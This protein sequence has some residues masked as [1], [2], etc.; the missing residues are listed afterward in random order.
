VVYTFASGGWSATAIANVNSQEA[1]HA[2]GMDHSLNCNSVMSYCGSG[3]G[4]FS[5]TCDG[6]C[7]Q[8]CQGAAG[9]RLFHEDFC[10]VGNDR[11][12]EIEELT[13]IFGGNEPDL[14]PPSVEIVSP[15]DGLVLPEGAD[16]NLR[17]IVDDDY[18]GY[19]W[20]FVI[21]HQGEV[22]YDQVDYDREVDAQYRAA[23]NLVNLEP[24]TYEIVVEAADHF[25]H[26]SSDV[27]TFVV[28][29]EV[30]PGDTEAD[31]TAGGGSGGEGGTA[32]E[33]SGGEGTGTATHE[34]PTAGAM[35]DGDDGC[36]CTSGPGR[37]RTGP[38]GL[39]VALLALGGLRRRRLR[40]VRRG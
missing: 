9:C 5:N 30:A 14:E 27:V 3:N 6:L 31:G 4:I 36:A 39:F 32:D 25:D 23:L 11:Q 22:V 10:G 28:E 20:R 16:V 12:N 17:A 37:A 24:G 35:A 1:G 7:E 33:G 19:G 21:S 38:A 8:Q 18:G 26:T 13:F 40:D 29:G 34:E 2:W 15:E